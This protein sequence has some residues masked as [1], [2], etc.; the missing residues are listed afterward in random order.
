MTIILFFYLLNSTI[1]FLAYE[2][3]DEAIFSLTFLEN[4][5]D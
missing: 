4:Q 3:V 5:F 2:S 1:S